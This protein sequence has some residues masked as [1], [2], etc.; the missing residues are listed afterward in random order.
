VAIQ[1]AVTGSWLLDTNSRQ[2]MTAPTLKG[3]RYRRHCPALHR[4]RWRRCRTRSAGVRRE[5]TARRRR[6]RAAGWP[7]AHVAADTGAKPLLTLEVLLT[8]ALSFKG[9]QNG[10]ALGHP[11][12]IFIESDH[13]FFPPAIQ[14]AR[15][16][17]ACPSGSGRSPSGEMW[18][19]R[20]SPRK[21]PSSG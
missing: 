6:A 19:R 14:A 11:R 21:P 4:A 3:G 8:N 12:P 10:S 17:I 15:S 7:Q 18:A 1:L 9:L 13:N 5:P 20:T 2:A 16:R